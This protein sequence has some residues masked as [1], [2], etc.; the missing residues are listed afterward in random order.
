[1]E[2]ETAIQP[3][4]GLTFTLNYTYLHP[5]EDVQSRISFTDTTYSYLLRRPKH[6]VNLTAGYQFA[7][8]LYISAGGKYVSKRYDVG[9]YMS[10]DE[11]LDSYVILNAYAEYRINKY[12]KVFAD[13]QNLT[14]KKFFDVRGYRSIPFMANGGIVITW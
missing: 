13:A 6:N 5:K 12:V 10:K 1:V 3:A 7:N 11:V 4:K 2:V 9:D 8:G 14:N